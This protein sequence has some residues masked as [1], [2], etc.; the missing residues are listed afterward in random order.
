MSG[1]GG[2]IIYSWIALPTLMYG[3]Y[4][5]L[6]LLTQAGALTLKRFCS[7]SRAACFQLVTLKISL[8]R[9]CSEMWLTDCES[10][11][12]CGFIAVLGSPMRQL[13]ARFQVCARPSRSTNFG[14]FPAT[15]NLNCHRVDNS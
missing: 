4:A 10:V 14:R 7:A 12:N 11:E 1:P 5:L 15:N 9:R 8:S 13:C 3:G 2:W 6:R